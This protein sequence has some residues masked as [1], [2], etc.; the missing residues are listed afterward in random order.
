MTMESNDKSNIYV[1]ISS[2]YMYTHTKSYHLQ[3]SKVQS[4]F[5]SK[6][7]N[8]V[9]CA[10]SHKESSLFNHQQKGRSLVWKKRAYSV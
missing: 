9:A 3:T 7:Y 10:T 6:K 8:H 5:L 4:Y 1:F 2:C